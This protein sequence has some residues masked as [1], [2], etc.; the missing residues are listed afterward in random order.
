MAVAAAETGTQPSA[1]LQGITRSFPGVLA[2]D[3]VTFDVYRGEIHA[4]IGENG[5][6]KSTLIKVLEGLLRPE[7]GRILLD[8]DEVLLHS[9]RD[10]RKRG[11]TVVPQEILAVPDL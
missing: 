9:V 2:L 11:I 6:G 10:A 1:L 5:A 4:L 8:G 7:S 3:H